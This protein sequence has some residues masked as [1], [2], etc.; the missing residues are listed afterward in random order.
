MT[1]VD[2]VV[3]ERDM[4]DAEFELAERIYAAVQRHSNF[5]ERSL[6][7]QNF[8]AGI[9]DLGYCSE[10][11]R[12][13]LGQEVPVDKDVLPAFIGTALGDHI[14]QAVKAAWPDD[15]VLIQSE[16][17]LSLP[18]ETRTYTLTGHP[19]MIFTDLG[20]MIDGKSSRGLTIARRAGLDQQKQFQRHCYGLAA[21]Q[22]GLFGDRPL[23]EIKVGNVWIDRAGDD[24]ELFVDM[25][26]LDLDI[27]EGAAQ[28]LDEVVYAYIN[29]QDANKEPPREVCAA[30]CGFYE[31]C[32]MLETDV[33]GLIHGEQALTAVEMYAEG[34]ELLKRGK[35]LRDQATAALRGVQG[36]T[37]EF[38]V[39]WIH[40]NG[41]SVAYD[42]KPYDRLDL[43]RMK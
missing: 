14:E 1:D 20:Y 40:V 11:L 25:E 26:P 9:S 23:E 35:A 2:E 19:D 41:T 13:M 8:Q 7:S 5:S 28:W 16:V 18:G 37:G 24:R 10:R 36:S 33:D 32:R 34:G 21:H 4:D 17:S 6:Q 38:T 43:R 3:P 12:R 22:A 30:T 31:T 29:E 42:R 27:V 15:E 39:R